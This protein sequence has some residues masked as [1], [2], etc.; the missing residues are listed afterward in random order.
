[1]ILTTF[2]VF[3]ASMVS[4]Q[5]PDDVDKSLYGYEGTLI[6]DGLKDTVTVY[7][8]ER[9]MPHIYA[10]NEHDLYLAVGFVSARER[11][12]Q[13][14]LIRRSTTGRLSEILGKSFLQV[15]LIS[16]CLQIT[17][18]SRK[19]LENEDPAVVTCMKAYVE[20]INLFIA[21]CRKLPLEFRLLSY[22]PEPWSLEDIVNII[23]LMGW[24]LGSRNLM[25]ELFNYQLVRKAG[26]EK[27]SSL[28]PD[29]ELASET[30]YPDFVLND[31]LISETRSL[32]SSFEKIMPLGI[33][34]FSGSNN[35]A[36]SGERS[37]TGKPILSNDMHLPLNNPSIWMQMHQVVPGKIN[38]TGVIIPGEPFI[39]AG[40]NEK[41]A[42]G[43]T[44]LMVDDVDLY[45]EKINPENHDQY[46]FNGQ[47]KD[48]VK[49]T[50]I[51]EIRGGR[52]D[53]VIISYTHRGPVISGLINPDNMPSKVK[54]MGWEYVAGLEHLQDLS[55]S[56]KWGGFDL[57]DE[58]KGI[59]LLNRAGNWDDFRSGTALFNSISQNF[60]YSDIYGNIGLQTGGGI[61]LRKGNGIMIRSGETGEFDWKGYVPFEQLPFSYN[62][63]GGTVS[64]ANNKTVSDYPYFISQDFVV[65]Y[66]IKRIREM[67]GQKETFNTEDFRKMILDQH[68]VLA[69]SLTPIILKLNDRRNDITE[70]GKAILDSLSRW[71]YRMSPSGI[72]P[73]V[74]EFFRMCLKKNIFADELGELYNEM[75]YMTSEYYIYRIV[76]GESDEW[77][78]NINTAETETL[79]DI[80]MKS[81]K[82]A[83]EMLSKLFGKNLS[84]W[85]WGKVH[86]I[87][88]IHPLGSVRLLGLLFNLNSKEYSIGGSDHTVCPY[89]SFD[90]LL[91]ASQGASIRHIYNTAD[92]D[93]SFSV[94]PGGIS[95]VPESEFYLSQVDTYIQGRFYSDH[96]TEKAVKKSAKYRL[97]LKPIQ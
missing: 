92:W 38:V 73:T 9:G 27:A 49:K 18:K 12:W 52:P 60:I 89:F 66:R 63:S 84:K 26:A 11:L 77:I 7:R 16:R 48:L 15:D 8:D 76:S 39:V 81:Y 34:L 53:T 40:H 23:G 33:P 86:K 91:R 44:N 57:S 82:D 79:D 30:I 47:W 85:Q 25:A 45:T 19:I 70:T 3:I 95:G 28:I 4:F 97:L 93:G 61:P 51:I 46:Y 94:L 87:T 74:L 35:W 56:F 5:S 2:L 32:V 17:E 41:I 13:M 1:M 37:E 80:V 42:W 55:L 64:S 68:S 90:S 20:G 21:N 10:E 22:S 65:P 50:E 78:D 54:W 58:V 62:P 59:Y 36:V 43:M 75:Y 67:L 83:M 14:D 72:A 96:F 71:D 31:T 6:L 69:R 88:F 24:S 29:W